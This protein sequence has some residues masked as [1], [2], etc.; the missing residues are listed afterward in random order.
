MNLQAKTHSLELGSYLLGKWT[1]LKACETCKGNSEPKPNPCTLSSSENSIRSSS[2]QLLPM[3]EMFSIPLRNSMK[4]P[5][6]GQ[7]HKVTE[8]F[9][10]AGREK[11]PFRGQ[12]NYS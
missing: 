11:Q 10:R 3:G 9:P 6:C 7:G 12:Y 5:L 4:V 8:V 1:R 2:V